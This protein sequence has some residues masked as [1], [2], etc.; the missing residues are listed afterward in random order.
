MANTLFSLLSILRRRRRSKMRLSDCLWRCSRGRYQRYPRPRPQA[1]NTKQVYAMRPNVRTGTGGA[2]GGSCRSSMAARSLCTTQRCSLAAAMA[3]DVRCGAVT[4]SHVLSVRIPRGPAPSM[5]SLSH[6]RPR[7]RPRQRQRGRIIEVGRLP[8]LSRAT[9]V[10]ALC[11]YE[12]GSRTSG[13]VSAAIASAR[14][15]N[16]TAQH[17]PQFHREVDEPWK[18]GLAIE[19]IA[20][21]VAGKFTNYERT[22][23]KALRVPW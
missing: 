8:C 3:I 20:R 21:I 9:A 10:Q 5:S 13:V 1:A 14:A 11:T 15:K 16:C 22:V 4:W 19:H 7:P 6:A 17:K 18:T 12:D 23:F 2:V